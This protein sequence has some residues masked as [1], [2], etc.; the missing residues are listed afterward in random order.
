[1]ACAP[2]LVIKNFLEDTR[3]SE[4]CL[5]DTEIPW[6]FPK[7]FSLSP[8]SHFQASTPSVDT[9][10]IHPP[11]ESSPVCCVYLPDV[12]L[13]SATTDFENSR[14]NTTLTGVAPPS[15]EFMLSLQGSAFPAGSWASSSQNHSMGYQEM[16]SNPMPNPL[17][18]NTN[19]SPTPADVSNQQSDELHDSSMN[20]RQQPNK[21]TSGSASRLQDS[22]AT[23]LVSVADQEA[24][25]TN[26]LKHDVLH[27]S[28]VSADSMH[29]HQHQSRINDIAIQHH[30]VDVTVDSV[31]GSHNDGDTQRNSIF[32][33]NIL[34]SDVQD[35]SKNQRIVSV[36]SESSGASLATLPTPEN[37]AT[38]VELPEQHDGAALEE[39]ASIVLEHEQVLAAEADPLESSALDTKIIPSTTSTGPS[40][41]RCA[42]LTDC[43]EVCLSAVGQ[44]PASADP[45]LMTIPLLFGSGAAAMQSSSSIVSNQEQSEAVSPSSQPE[46]PGSPI[47]LSSAVQYEAATVSAD[48]TDREMAPMR[49]RS[50]SVFSSDLCAPQSALSFSDPKRETAGAKIGTPAPQ[51]SRG[52]CYCPFLLYVS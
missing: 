32:L 44:Q 20:A 24:R 3:P 49:K 31:E 14:V 36:T 48:R 11:S 5:E 6:L 27:M 16:A 7:P 43:N 4:Q 15:D 25:S 37:P 13:P 9:T 17:V 41:N 26:D 38:T 39:G 2:E 45:T 47:T 18:D 23:I 40:T 50:M 1:M 19:Q 30:G 35:E 46:P 10:T 22:P 34:D 12:R 8:I 29:F 52:I 51:G 28:E 21:V 33:E 42:R